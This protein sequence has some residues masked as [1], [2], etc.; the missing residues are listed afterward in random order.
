[1]LVFG[2]KSGVPHGKQNESCLNCHQ[3]T[4]R[5]H[6]QGSAHET[7]DLSCASCHM[8]HQPDGVL[9]RAKETEVCVTCHMKERSE[10]YRA[11]SHPIRE[12]K[13][14]CTDC[15]NPHGSDGP[16]AL[17]ALTVNQKCYRCHAEKRGP[18][19]WEHEPVTENCIVCHAPHG[20]NNPALLVRRAPHLCQQCHQ[21]ISGGSGGLGH[22]RR[23]Y[24]FSL[25]ESNPNPST[26]TRGPSRFV[27]GMSCMNCHSQVHGSNHPSGRALQR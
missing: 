26:G 12:G 23:Y 21:S 5:I 4:Q 16:K 25:T 11:S 3:D 17:S 27:L 9:F 13:I 6:W 22:I 15:H 1:M 14:I 7:A 8:I 18:F 2:H 24:D 10:L 20:S 19:L